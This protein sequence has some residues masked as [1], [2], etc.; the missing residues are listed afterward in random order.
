MYLLYLIFN[1]FWISPQKEN[2]EHSS[3]RQVGLKLNSKTCLAT[4]HWLCVC[5]R[6]CVFW[7]LL[8]CFVSF[9]LEFH[10][11]NAPSL[12]G[13]I[14]L[15][16]QHIFTLEKKTIKIDYKRKYSTKLFWYISVWFVY[17]KQNYLCRK[18]RNVY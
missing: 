13:A 17:S 7:L 5:L 6:V 4:R 8:L 2:I 11:K 16:H 15:H 18:T 9:D 12:F 14:Q 3:N 10:K 1:Y